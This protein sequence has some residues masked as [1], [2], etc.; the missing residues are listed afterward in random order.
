[1][2]LLAV[3]GSKRDAQRALRKALTERDHGITID[4]SKLTVAEHLERWLDDHASLRVEPATLLRYRQIATRL[5]PLIGSIRLADLQAA[6]IQSAYRRLL[7]DGLADRTVL[8][9]HRVLKQALKH[10]V[11]WKLLAANPADAVTPPRPERREMRSLSAEEV[12]RLEAAAGDDDYRRLITVSVS[13]GLRLGELLGLKWSDVDFDAGRVRVQRTLTY[14]SRVL[15]LASLKTSHSRRVVAL[16]A[17]TVTT[18]REHRAA[19]L[20]RRLA[21]GEVYAEQGLVFPAENGALLPPYRVSNRF[22]NLCRREGLQGVRWHDLRHTMATLALGAGVNVKIVSE[23]LGHS[24]TQI[25]LDT[26][27]H[28][29]PDMQEAAAEALDVALRRPTA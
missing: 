22:T 27:S 13:T 17:H 28:V 3:R 11:L 29:L 9:H 6:H 25:T 7:D 18:L 8:H 4:P 5:T 20:E 21:L 1:V 16:S 2:A 15:A 23:R 19:Q 24:T 14:L 10:A 26:Y 12:T